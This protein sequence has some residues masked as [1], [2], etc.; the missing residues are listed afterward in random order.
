MSFRGLLLVLTALCVA[1]TAVAAPPLTPNGWGKL[2]IGMRERDAI[3]LFHLRVP[4]G[5]GPDSF[6]C[7][8][9]EVPSQEGLFVM[10]QR[11][12]ITRIS[13]EAPSRL[14]TDRGVGLGATEAEIKRAYG[15]ALKIDTTPYEEEPAHQLVFWAVPNKRGV[16][17]DTNIAGSVEAIYVGADAI[18]LIE[19]CS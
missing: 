18:E 2:R 5:L 1:T 8:Q 19:G 7:R 6:D 14:L 11:G 10:A 16:R 13:I 3:R 9:D 12:V 4:R 15:K 17:Y